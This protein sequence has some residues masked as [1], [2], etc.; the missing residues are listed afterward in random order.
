MSL[1][2][3]IV[4]DQA[5]LCLLASGLFGPKASLDIALGEARKAAFPRAFSL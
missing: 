4:P 2:L 5:S 3:P 1:L